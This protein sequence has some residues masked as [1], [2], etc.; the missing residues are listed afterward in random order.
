[1]LGASVFWFD[2]SALRNIDR[3]PSRLILAAAR[4]LLEIDI[5]E[6]LAI[7]LAHDEAGIQRGWKVA[8]QRVIRSVVI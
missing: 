4:L 7:V 2:V 1:M 3:N 6:R 8:G 5:G